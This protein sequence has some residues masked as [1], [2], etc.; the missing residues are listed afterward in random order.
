MFIND[1]IATIQNIDVDDLIEESFEATSLEHEATI[2]EQMAVGQDEF[3]DPI[4]QY[5]SD[6]YADYKQR[7]G[8]RAP[9]GVVD[10]KKTGS[11]A[12]QVVVSINNGKLVVESEDGDQKKQEDIAKRYGNFHLY[13][14]EEYR[15]TFINDYLRPAFIQSIKTRIKLR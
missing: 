9:Y 8:S 2:R 1:L 13:L 14:N 6:D 4:G 3:G 12:R 5:R 10:L 7:L 15:K 11:Y